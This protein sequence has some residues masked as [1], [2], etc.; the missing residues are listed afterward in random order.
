M[1]DTST[2]CARTAEYEGSWSIISDN[3][4]IH[5]QIGTRIDPTLRLA[6]SL[7]NQTGLP[8]DHIYYF[9]LLDQT[10]LTRSYQIK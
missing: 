2:I 7:R 8:T 3:L 4:S 9:Y 6:L 5:I 1:E 10:N